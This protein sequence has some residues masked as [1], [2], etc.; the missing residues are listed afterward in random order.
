MNPAGRRRRG[1]LRQP[2]GGVKAER[3]GH[4]RLLTK[5][6]RQVVGRCAAGWV[7]M[8]VSA[9]GLKFPGTTRPAQTPRFTVDHRSAHRLS[10]PNRVNPAEDVLEIK[11]FGK[12]AARHSRELGAAF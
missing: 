11:D 7:L 5:R 3:G 6:T 12:P 1:S 8:R 2:F 10:K 9:S 4:A